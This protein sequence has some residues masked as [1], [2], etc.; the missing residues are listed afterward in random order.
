MSLDLTL[1]AFDEIWAEAEQQCAPV[2]TIDGLEMIYTVPASLGQGYNRAINLMPG[3]HLNIFHETFADV[4]IRS[5]EQEHLVQFIV[6]LSGVADSGDLVLINTAQGYIGGSGIQRN[7]VN[8]YPQSQPRIGVNIHLEPQLVQQMFALPTGELPAEWHPLL[9]GDR[10]QRVFTPKTT[11]AI[12]S[13]VQQMIDCPFQ[14]LTKRLYLQ[15][16]VLELMALQLAQIPV[17]AVAKVYS[18]PKPETIAQVH[19]AAEILRS[20]LEHPPS[21]T[22]L[23]QRV[24]MSDRTLQRNFRAVLGMNPFAYL[25]QQRMQVAKQLL[26]ASDRTV[27][28]VANLVGYSHPA[29]FATAFKRQFGLLPHQCLGKKLN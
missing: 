14:G 15:G 17:D 28:E 1:E 27:A 21:L 4:T 16:K 5:S 20:Q 3:F 8:Y 10:P 12:R 26:Q 18:Q 24:G 13:V 25:T 9:Q 23:A 22:E 29:H 19:Y 2:T 7:H 6:N 11:P